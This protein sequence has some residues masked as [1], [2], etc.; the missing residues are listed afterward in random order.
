MRWCYS[1]CNKNMAASARAAG[2]I[3]LAIISAFIKSTRGATPMVQFT[4]WPA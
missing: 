4:G 1:M 3:A 2:E